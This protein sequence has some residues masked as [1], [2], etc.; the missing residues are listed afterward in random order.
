MS[1]LDG[2]FGKLAPGNVTNYWE[3]SSVSISGSESSISFDDD[4]LFESIK[5]NIPSSSFQGEPLEFITQ[6][7]FEVYN[8]VDYELG[9]R[10]LVSGAFEDTIIG[11][12]T[13]IS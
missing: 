2:G 1:D 12:T 13:V 9:F 10:T 6:N 4:L 11:E 7:V 8:G 5:F 3:T